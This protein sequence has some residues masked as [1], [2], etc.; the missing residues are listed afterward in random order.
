MPAS[1][2]RRPRRLASR[3]C[4]RS[5]TPFCG[6][7]ARGA[8]DFYVGRDDADRAFS[9]PRLGCSHRTPN[10]VSFG[11]HVRHTCRQLWPATAPDPPEADLPRNEQEE[12]EGNKRKRGGGRGK[13]KRR[14][15]LAEG[16]DST[17]TTTGELGP[18]TQPQAVVDRLRTLIDDVLIQGGTGEGPR[19]VHGLLRRLETQRQALL[20]QAEHTLGLGANRQA[21]EA[22][23]Q[24]RQALLDSPGGLLTR[25]F[26]RWVRAGLTAVCL[27]C[28]C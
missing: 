21:T 24:T 3:S 12:A 11:L 17:T 28:A 23:H 16:S 25:G 9:C 22:L 6:R 4:Y 8:S 10:T 13:G 14:K 5:L 27:L 2:R 26:V 1:V 7:L 20:A 19:T 15:G 18:D